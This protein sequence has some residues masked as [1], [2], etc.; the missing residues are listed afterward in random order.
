VT[1][2]PSERPSALG[3]RNCDSLSPKRSSNA[4]VMN[5]GSTDEAVVIVKLCAGELM[6]TW[7]RVKHRVSN[8]MLEVKGGT[9]KRPWP[10]IIDWQSEISRIGTRGY[11]RRKQRTNRWCKIDERQLQLRVK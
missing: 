7:G 8:R 3:L 11:P 6:A 1:I 4:D 9:C 5:R 2:L 10:L